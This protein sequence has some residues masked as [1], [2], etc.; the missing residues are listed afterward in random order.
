MVLIGAAIGAAFK[1]F[2]N[3]RND[4]GDDAQGDHPIVR[5]LFRAANS[6][7]FSGVDDIIDADCEFFAN[8]FSLQGESTPSG[9]DFAAGTL[10]TVQAELDDYRWQLFDELSGRDDGV[11]KIA[12]RFVATATIDGEDDSVEI[13]AFAT[14]KDDK[15]I[16]WREVLD[17]TLANRRR[18]AAGLPPIE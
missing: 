1:F 14:I 4:A 5:A 10:R 18:K 2:G 8:G 15:I 7:D 9:P 12:I 11:E 13:A 16:E 3:D 6:R 17:M